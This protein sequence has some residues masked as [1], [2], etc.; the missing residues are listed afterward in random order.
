MRRIL[1]STLMTVAILGGSWTIYHRD[2]IESP[3][4]ALKLAQRQLQSLSQNHASLANWSRPN[5]SS[6][7]IASFNIQAFGETKASQPE[8][9]AML[10]SIVREFDIVAI[11]EIRSKDQRLLSRFTDEIN[12]GGRRFQFIASQPLGRTT[13]REQYA[14][15][16]D[17]QTVQLD[18]ARSYIIDD[19]DG[20]LHREPMVGWFRTKQAPPERAFTFTLVNVHLDSRTP[21]REVVHLNQIFRVIRND[22][23]GEDDV[24]IV[25]DFNLSSEAMADTANRS[26]LIWLVDNVPTNTRGTTQYDNIIIDPRATTEF[27]GKAGVYDF[28][29]KFNL[30]LEQ[31]LT[32]SD[33]LPVWAEFGVM[34]GDYNEMV[35]SSS[36]SALH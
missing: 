32:V 7:R 19:P 14:F 8:V 16:Y 30:T 2:Q 4:D 13:Y 17:S 31:A 5:Q 9:M 29:K 22:G 18:S 6:I 21:Q 35:A 12:A 26:G 25:G 1:I 11:Q 28:L 36:E 20:L 27:T 23:R 10:A 15:I 33:H 3:H 24:I 34:E